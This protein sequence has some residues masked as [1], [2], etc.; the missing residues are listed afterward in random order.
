MQLNDDLSAPSQPQR[1]N[2]YPVSAKEEVPSL[3]PDRTNLYSRSQIP[4][5]WFS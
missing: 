4:W 1:L 2:G 3:L 5:L